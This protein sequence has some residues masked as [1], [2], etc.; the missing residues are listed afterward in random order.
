MKNEQKSLARKER[1]EQKQK[2]KEEKYF[3]KYGIHPNEVEQK[4]EKFKIKYTWKMFRYLKG[5]GWSIFLLISILLVILVFDVARPFFLMSVVDLASVGD[6]NAAMIYVLLFG[7][8]MLNGPLWFCFD[9]TISK[10]SAKL[11]HK[12]RVDMV[13]ST[14]DSQVKYFDKISSGTI[15]SRVNGDPGRFINQIGGILRQFSALMQ[16]VSIAIVFFVVDWRIGSLVLVLSLIL[17]V[18]NMTYYKKSVV[19]ADQRNL[20]INDNYESQST[21]MIRGIR[22]IKNLN[23]FTHFYSRFNSVSINR[24]NSDIDVNKKTALYENV[25]AWHGLQDV[26]EIAIILLALYFFSIG[27]IT[28]GEF[29]TV[30]MYGYAPF[31]MVHRIGYINGSLMR[32]EVAARRMYEIIDE[33]QNPKEVFGNVE[34]HNAKGN[35]EFKDV[36]FSYNDEKVFEKLNLKIKAC[37]CVGFVGKSGEGKSTILS[38]IPR[39]YD[40]SSGKVLIDGVD[41][42]ELTKDSLREN[43]SVVSQSPYIFNMSIKENLKLVKPDATDK[44]IKDACKRA[45]IWDFIKSKPE[46]LNTKVG[47]GGVVLS[48][49][50]KQRIAIA[51][52]FLKE[53]KVLLLDEATSALDNESQAE[54][55]KAIKNMKKTCTIVIVA[56]RLSTVQDCDK[57]FVL[58]NHKI[59]GEG[60]HRNLIKSCK[61]YKNLYQQEE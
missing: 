45:A 21:E 31:A 20:K 47:E 61:A 49:G 23:I 29:T 5:N 32:M 34:L 58:E 3:Q 26:F 14:A 56:H 51:R 57:I 59:V 9:Y 44:E 60:S 43:V 18:C 15:L 46:G 25:F 7:L 8:F 28:L 13:K 11:S 40:V 22:D 39:L 36:C 2:L 37:E 19:P 6:W 35:I 17:L 24:K 10:M 27:N 38:L 30:L 52:A 4:Q 42:R 54:V 16:H 55:K 50:Q 53:S 12:M 33:Q 48:G 1:K 41:V